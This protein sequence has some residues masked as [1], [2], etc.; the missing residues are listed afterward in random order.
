MDGRR[1]TSCGTGN[2]LDAKFCMQCGTAL[3]RTCPSCGTDDNPPQARFCM[4]CG[5]ALDGSAA[6]APSPASGPAPFT[7]PPL[8]PDERRFVSVLFADLSGYTSI[9]ENL[10]PEALKG[11][12]ERCLRRLGGEVVS[13]GGTVDKYIGDN[14]MALF[15]APTAHEDDPERAVRAGLAMQ[16][17]MEEI[18]ERTARENGITFALRVGINTGEVAAGKVGDG[19]TVIGDAVN[20]AA[21]LQAAARPGTVTVGERTWRATQD[22]IAYEP[23]EPLTP[24]GKAEPVPA[25]EAG[26]PIARPGRAEARHLDSPFIGRDDELDLLDQLFLRVQRESRPHLV[27]LIGQAG[28]GKSRLLREAGTRLKECGTKPTFRHGRSLPYG[29]GLVYW[30]LGEVIR[31]EAAIHD[32]DSSEVAW[33]KLVTAIEALSDS[34]MASISEEPSDR[35][36]AL[37]GR[38]VGIEA[39]DDVPVVETDDPAEA[40]ERFFS[41]A[42]AF[43]EGMARRG[44]LVIAWE[45][46]HWADEGMLDLIEYL[47]Q[48]VSGPLLML[49]LTRDELLERRPSWG[50]GRRSGTSIFLEPLSSDETHTLVAALVDD[51]HAG[52][53]SVSAVVARAGGN[54]LFAEEL[55]RGLVETE[56]DRGVEGLPDTVHGLLAARLDALP[57]LER[58]V[59]QDASVVGE[60]FWAGVLEP[61]VGVPSQELRGALTA[62]QERDVVRPAPD[63][64][65]L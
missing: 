12:V 10:D 17:A 24:K 34:G 57:P 54:P 52:D 49:C 31:S 64:G 9:A 23:L 3:A 7:E 28:V 35:R 25:F 56:D 45:D 1:C 32:D 11:L 18:N 48:W 22:A 8:P 46:V 40:R 20:V 60:Q 14:V 65:R 30:A 21:R 61:L 29:T 42:R 19:Y 5:A 27:T 15:G 38:L 62:L 44:P 43:V 6:A 47:A 59:I 16:A 41:A 33:H 2:P 63:T 39:P 55:A 36:A 13:H 53:E 4:S 51:E 37:I 26:G 50:G 58:R